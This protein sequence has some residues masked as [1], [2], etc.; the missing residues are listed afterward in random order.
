M[1]HRKNF[2]VKLV[3]GGIIAAVVIVVLVVL[4]ILLAVFVPRATSNN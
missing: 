4:I 1:L 3:I 2:R